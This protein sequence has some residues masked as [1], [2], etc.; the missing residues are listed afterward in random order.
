M[1]LLTD[2]LATITGGRAMLDSKAEVGHRARS[3]D[4]ALL[5]SIVAVA[6]RRAPVHNNIGLARSGM[7]DR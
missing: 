1:S 4:P 2:A 7:M 6:D 3:D 5:G